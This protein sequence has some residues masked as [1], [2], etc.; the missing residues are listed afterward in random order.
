M[1]ARWRKLVW[2]VPFNGMTVLFSSTA[3]KLMA[4]ESTARMAKELMFEVARGAQVCGRVIG[5]DFVELMLD[6][7]LKMAPTNRACCLI[8]RGAGSWS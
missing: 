2:N 6:H 8:M 5:Q 7:T 3:D 4:N 1:L